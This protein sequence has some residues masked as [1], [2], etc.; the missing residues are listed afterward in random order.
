[1]AQ[2]VDVADGERD[3]RLVQGVGEL[4]PT[5]GVGDHLEGV[6]GAAETDGVVGPHERVPARRGAG[7]RPSGAEA[8]S[9]V[10]DGV[11]DGVAGGRA[12]RRTGAEGEHGRPGLAS[13]GLDLVLS[14]AAAHA[15]L[16]AEPRAGATPLA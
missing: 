16:N 7:S 8:V 3:Q 10:A 2:R 15:R 14:G 11:A 4:R 1:M 5:V 9:G 12:V 13:S 6:L